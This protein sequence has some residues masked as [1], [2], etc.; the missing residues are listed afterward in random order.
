MQIENRV[1]A[2]TVRSLNAKQAPDN[3]VPRM[4]LEQQRNSALA[5]TSKR[6]F[7]KKRP[8]I[9]HAIRTVK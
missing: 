4:F 9:S 5:I 8:L 3:I 1:A 6:N 7:N 2:Y